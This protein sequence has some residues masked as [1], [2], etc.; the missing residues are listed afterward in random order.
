[1]AKSLCTVSLLASSLLVS[2]LL[3]G[4]GAQDPCEQV[5]ALLSDCYPGQTSTAQCTPEMLS[6]FEE[7]DMDT[8]TCEMI[9]MSSKGDFSWCGKGKHRCNGL[10]CC[11]DYPIKVW[12]HEVKGDV[13]NIIGV[14]DTYQAA[15]PDDIKQKI[16]NLSD[17]EL[18]SISSSF[19]FNQ[20][21]VDLPEAEAEAKLLAVEISLGLIDLPYADFI[22]RLPPADWGINLAQHLGGKLKVIAEETYMVGAEERKRP[23]QQVERMVLSPFPVKVDCDLSNQDMTKTEVITYEE[24][25]AKVYWRVY[26]SVNESTDTD[27]GSVEFRSFEG[28][29][30]VTFHSAHRLRFPKL[31][32][33]KEG[34]FIPLVLTRKLLNGFFL[35]HIRHYQ[36]LVGAQP[37]LTDQEY[38]EPF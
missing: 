11:D 12:P 35:G 18:E 21:V 32:F 14:I 38:P 6:F 22:Q 30:L 17:K 25:S 37:L 26:N 36:D 9:D 33:Q 7:Q 16:E 1:M 19:T 2:S 15:T 27:V 28:K 8:M 34:T 31:P 29:T 20:E 24:D 4:C 5:Q 13:W 23:I 3:M 10:I